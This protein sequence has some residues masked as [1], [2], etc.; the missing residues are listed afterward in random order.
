MMIPIL[1]YLLSGTIFL[2]AVMWVAGDFADGKR[3][4]PTPR[5]VL[6]AAMEPEDPQ[7]VHQLARVASAAAGGMMPGHGDAAAHDRLR[8]PE[9]PG[10][11]P[12]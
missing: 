2:T 10:P 6:I 5:M 3:L 12:R 9:H 8:C 11:R 1:L 7:P 4:Q